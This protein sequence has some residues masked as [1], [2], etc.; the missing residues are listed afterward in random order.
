MAGTNTEERS[1][2]A[3]R[4]LIVVRLGETTLQQAFGV[5]LLSK[6]TRVSHRKQ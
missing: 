6:D 2:A 4:V 5:V 1:G 3:E